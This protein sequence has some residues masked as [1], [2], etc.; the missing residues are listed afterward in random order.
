MAD[1]KS[2]AAKAAVGVAAGVLVRSDGAVLLARRPASK[3]YS[4][5][6]EFPGGKVEPGETP[7]EALRR[8]IREELSVEVLAEHPWITRTFTYP[9]AT[10][11]LHFFRVTSWKGELVPTEHDAVAWQ[12]PGHMGVEPMLPANGP[13]L[14]ALALPAEY[15]V[16]DA[17]GMGED[18]FLK[19]LRLRL[20]AGVRLVQWREPGM[21]KADF[22]RLG[23][24]VVE[25]C[26]AQGARVLV[27][28]D[29]STARALGAD[30]IHLTA[31]SLKAVQARPDFPL[32]AASCHD[33]TELARAESIG[34]DFAVL[35]S[36]RA[37]PSHPGEA[38]IGW[39]RFETLACDRGIPVYA[40]GGLCIED[41]ELARS[42]G[43]HGIAMIRGAWR[44]A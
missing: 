6:W 13:V 18:E 1:G 14:S 40:I 25:L 36:L 42:H 30:G 29:A 34:V 22:E 23:R 37:T 8:E 44:A 17:A 2:P 16:S 9:H 31:A 38:G 33:A 27:N 43:A 10:V 21:P 39:E 15:A 24:Q 7:R 28:G 3:V 4:G 12:M 11:R 20:E 41:L 35:G 19:R 26:H 32:V 5:Y